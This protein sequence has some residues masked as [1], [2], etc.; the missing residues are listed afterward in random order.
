MTASCGHDYEMF[1]LKE[2]VWNQIPGT[3]DAPEDSMTPCLAC[4][5]TLL[6]RQMTLG[7]ISVSS[8]LRTTGMPTEFLR[9][10]VKAL[11]CGA[12]TACMTPLPNGWII[13][14]ELPHT[15]AAAH[16]KK[17]A[18]QSASPQTALKQLMLDFQSSFGSGKA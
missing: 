5:E 6:A 7:D 11:L 1:W 18:K 14:T 15:V 10:Y 9:E 17:L 3:K 8:Y 12:F 2:V 16:G 13:P 4:A